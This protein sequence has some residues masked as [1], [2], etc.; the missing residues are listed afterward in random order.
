MKKRWE[1]YCILFLLLLSIVAAER[2][3][4]VKFDFYQNGN[5]FLKGFKLAEGNP[6]E[7]ANEIGDIYTL[8]VF[9]EK[10]GLAYQQKI[11]PTYS[12]GSSTA[13]VFLD[14][15]YKETYDTFTLKKGDRLYIRKSIH[16]VLCNL[17]DECSAFETPQT[18]PEDCAPET[19]QGCKNA[20]DGVCDSKC[21]TDP[22]C[23]TTR[24]FSWIYFLL[25]FMIVG[26]CFYGYAEYKS[27]QAK[28]VLLKSLN[29]PSEAT[30]GVAP[31]KTA[32]VTGSS[33]PP[34]NPSQPAR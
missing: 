18:C 16:Q 25:A 14:L 4:Q 6:S 29:L 17:D 32:P 31:P 30:I 26:V 1:L 8:Q 23:R 24:A 7:P 19:L 5:V 10:G 21:S 12:A 13:S 20:P 34:T 28:H 11:K 22:D 15:P 3:M 9:D 33:S 27:I 2:V